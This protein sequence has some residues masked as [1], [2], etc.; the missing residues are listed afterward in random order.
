MKDI[1]LS[2]A[3]LTL[4]EVLKLAAEHNVILRTTEGREFVLAEID[5][6]A[7]EVALVRENSALMQLLDER[8]KEKGRFSIEQIRDK[9]KGT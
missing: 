6:F 8:S 3:S 4:D 9:L 7:R 1:D 2:T 5:D